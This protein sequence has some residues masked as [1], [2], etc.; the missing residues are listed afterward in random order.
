MSAVDTLARVARRHAE[1]VQ[2]RLAEADAYADACAERVRAH[3]RD[4]EAEQQVARDNPFASFGAY[5][6]ASLIRRAALV[7]EHARALA[8]AAALRETLTDAFVE[9]KKLETLA[10]NER[11]AARAEEDRR[12]Q[13]ELDDVAGRMAG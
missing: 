10:E 8:A 3:D 5:V 1:E 7:S 12:E 4:M 13:A 9:L 6:T 2:R 11:V